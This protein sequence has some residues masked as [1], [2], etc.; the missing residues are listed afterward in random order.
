MDYIF[1]IGLMAGILTT[2]SFLPQFL[3]AWKSKS[4]GDI[5]LGTC[6]L[7]T[8][9]IFFWL[10]YGILKADLPIIIANAISLAITLGILFLKI[11]HG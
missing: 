6:T 7:I 8:I 5:S 2:V 10:C 4:T 3:K 9:G 1:L 11:K